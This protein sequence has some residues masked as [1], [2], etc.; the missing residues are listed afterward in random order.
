ML[1]H[2]QQNVQVELTA[3]LYKFELYLLVQKGFV[4]VYLLNAQTVLSSC[5]RARAIV[6]LSA[7]ICNTWTPA[8]RFTTKRCLHFGLVSPLNNTFY[9]SHFILSDKIGT[10]SRLST[11][12]NISISGATD[13]LSCK[14]LWPGL[15]SMFWCVCLHLV[16]LQMKTVLLYLV[17]V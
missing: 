17:S 10:A 4:T 3:R 6:L 13:P 8:L 5:I 1:N 9:V 7:V 16:R 11:A 2:V 12:F 14:A 15:L